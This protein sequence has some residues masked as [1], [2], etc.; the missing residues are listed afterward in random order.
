M[1]LGKGL[2]KKKIIVFDLSCIKAM[3]FFSKNK[4]IYIFTELR[5]IINIDYLYLSKSSE[6]AALLRLIESYLIDH[7]LHFFLELYILRFDWFLKC[8]CCIVS[9]IAK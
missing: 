2:L 5:G 6:Y 1:T 4:H 8:N 3:H 9:T 7:F